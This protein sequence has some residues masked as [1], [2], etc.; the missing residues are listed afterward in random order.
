MECSVQAQLIFV[1]FYCTVTFCR[2]SKT[3]AITNKTTKCISICLF[4][5]LLPKFMR[6]NSSLQSILHQILAILTDSWHVLCQDCCCV[7]IGSH[8]FF[9]RTHYHLCQ[10]QKLLDICSKLPPLNYS[11]ICWTSL[12]LYS[13]LSWGCSYNLILASLAIKKSSTASRVVNFS[14]G[15]QVNSF[16]S[17]EFARS[18]LKV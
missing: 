7:T 16:P 13:S 3:R 11:A 9:S 6:P 15:I 2:I 4:A 5:N 14:Q 10:T 12:H 17:D 8:C 1:L 18:V